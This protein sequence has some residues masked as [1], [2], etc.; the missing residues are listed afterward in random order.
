MRVLVATGDAAL[1]AALRDAARDAGYEAD[2]AMDAHELRDALHGGDVGLAVLDDA[3]A[4]DP[5][6]IEAVRRLRGRG[7]RVLALRSYR[8]RA[9]GN[10]T[11]GSGTAGD[12]ATDDAGADANAPE[13]DDVLT[14]PCS[15]AEFLARL[16]AAERGGAERSGLIIR[17]DLRIDTHRRQAFYG[18]TD[19]PLALSPRE[20]EALEV[21][22]QANGRFMD[23]DEIVRAVQAD[24]FFDQREIMGHALY[25][26]EKKLR[27]AGFMLT[28]RGD[29]Y[30][31]W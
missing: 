30:R 19:V 14:M 10:G 5:A 16:G 13:C 8:D 3:M 31:I 1:A 15:D 25:S 9:G 27:R 29:R 23:F 22:A 12:G 7:M 4:L 18:N 21:L 17:G 28:Q 11:A 26:L 20:Y 6:A 24:G 2:A